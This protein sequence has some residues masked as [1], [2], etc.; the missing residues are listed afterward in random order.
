MIENADQM[1][2]ILADGEWISINDKL[3]NVGEKVIVLCIKEM[4]YSGNVFD[5]SSEWLDDGLGIRA[6]LMW[7]KEIDGGIE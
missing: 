2:R 6:I 1:K 5:N 7:K 3:P 4:F